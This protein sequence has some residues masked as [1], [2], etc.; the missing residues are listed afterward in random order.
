MERGSGSW[1]ARNE[2]LIKMIEGTPAMILTCK[3]VKTVASA[4]AFAGNMLCP[5]KPLPMLFQES[6][7]DTGM[8]SCSEIQACDRTAII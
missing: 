1:Q 4:L 2:V 6:P 3:M 7:K 8:V 5:L